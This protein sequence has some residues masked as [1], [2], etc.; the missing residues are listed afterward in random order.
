MQQFIL[1]LE[2]IAPMII[3]L[4]IGYTLKHTN[5]VNDNFVKIGNRFT[6]YVTLPV[7]LFSSF[8]SIDQGTDFNMTYVL[9][10]AFTVIAL[11]AFG[12]LMLHFSRKFTQY[13]KGAAVL[14]LVRG[15]I[16]VF[17]Y[18]LVA[19]LYLGAGSLEM[20]IAGAVSAPLSALLSA[21]VLSLYAPSDKKKTALQ[22]TLTVLMNPLVLAGV[23]GFLF[24]TLNIHLPNVVMG[25]LNDIGAMATPFALLMI[26]AGFHFSGFG[27]Q[28]KRLSWIVAMKMVISPLLFVVVALLMGFRNYELAAILTVVATPNAVSNYAMAAEMGSDS[29][30][31]GDS[32]ILSVF[33]APFTLFTFIYILLTLGWL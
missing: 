16:L 1:S 5:I 15:N 6:F 19:G 33:I 7:L 8:N 22:L 29:K 4:V 9:F 30:I 32:I 18:P 12:V 25:A 24:Y 13:E 20:S 27:R 28:M 14:S 10:I 2:V 11:N 17:G 23:I 26:G 21:L 3:F 31:A